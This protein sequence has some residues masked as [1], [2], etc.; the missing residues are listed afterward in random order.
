MYLLF[1]IIAPILNAR[2]PKQAYKYLRDPT[3]LVWK[4]LL[5]PAVT[6][7]VASNRWSSPQD[8]GDSHNISNKPVDT[9]RLLD[10]RGKKSIFQHSV[11]TN[12]VNRKDF[13]H[14]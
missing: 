2:D 4:L 10:L 13:I 3:E 6:M 8:G 5:S 14:L 7:A 12:L 11:G 1:D 9:I